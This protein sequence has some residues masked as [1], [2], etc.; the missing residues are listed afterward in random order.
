MAERWAKKTKKRTELEILNM[1]EDIF[2]HLAYD[3]EAEKAEREESRDC[4]QEIKLRTLI[5]MS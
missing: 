2:A 3:E 4:D 1:K 5:N